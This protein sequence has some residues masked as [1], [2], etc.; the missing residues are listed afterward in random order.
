MN[1]FLA[2]QNVLPILVG[3]DEKYVQRCLFGDQR[4]LTGHFL[5]DYNPNKLGIDFLK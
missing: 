3:L 4:P 1:H 5:T 2:I